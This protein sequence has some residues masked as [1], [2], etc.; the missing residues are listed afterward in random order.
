MVQNLNMSNMRNDNTEEGKALHTP[1]YPSMLIWSYL[2]WHVNFMVL[3]WSVSDSMPFALGSLH[4]PR[5]RSPW[6][7][8]FPLTDLV[9]MLLRSAAKI[10]KPESSY[11]G[12]YHPYTYPYLFQGFSRA[13]FYIHF[14][15]ENAR[16]MVSRVRL[17]KHPSSCLDGVLLQPSLM[18]LTRITYLIKADA[19]KILVLLCLCIVCNSSWTAKITKWYQM[20]F[21]CNGGL[22]Q[23]SLLYS[24]KN[25][26]KPTNYIYPII[27]IWNSYC[28]ELLVL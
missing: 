21:F 8:D 20:G 16:N 6:S 13:P 4:I 7:D 19:E 22:E 12:P 27:S 10:F 9:A 23:P 14:N 17:E 25:H 26:W 15:E 3:S 28:L 1:P 24:L 11:Q 2:L 5:P 18:P